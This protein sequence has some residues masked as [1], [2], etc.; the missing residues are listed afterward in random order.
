MLEHKMRSLELFSQTM[1]RPEN[2]LN[3]YSTW[4]V[5]IWSLPNAPKVR[6]NYYDENEAQ[7]VCTHFMTELPF[8]DHKNNGSNQLTFCGDKHYSTK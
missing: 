5:Q 3:V 2:K 6:T 7:L 4:N 1:C 8:L